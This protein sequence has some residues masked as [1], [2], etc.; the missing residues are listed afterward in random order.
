MYVCTCACECRCACMCMH[1]CLWVQIYV[2]VVL[3]SLEKVLFAHCT[4]GS[5]AC[6]L[7][8]TLLSPL[9]SPQRGR[10]GVR[11][12][13]DFTWLWGFKPLLCTS[14]LTHWP[15]PQIVCQTELWIC[16]K[17]TQEIQLGHSGQLR[18]SLRQKGKL[19]QWLLTVTVLKITVTVLGTQRHCIWSCHRHPGPFRF[20]DPR[21]HTNIRIKNWEEAGCHGDPNN[22]QLSCEHGMC[23]FKNLHTVSEHLSY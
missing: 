9:P 16:R 22:L 19:K 8:G 13:L 23:H 14:T 4:P 12:R 17:T 1:L 21:V 5:L 7:P 6:G 15:H 2:R 11:L 18:D 3:T 10:L 20:T